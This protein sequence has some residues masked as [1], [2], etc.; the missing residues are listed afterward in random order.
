MAFDFTYTQKSAHE[1]FHPELTNSTYSVE[2][3]FDAGLD[4]NV[5]LLSMAELE[6]LMCL[7]IEK[8]NKLT[9]F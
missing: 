9:L 4:N 8:I 2:L 6:A 1:S 7:Q 5:D 3:N